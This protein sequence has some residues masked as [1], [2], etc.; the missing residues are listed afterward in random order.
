M[1][2]CGPDS[3]GKPGRCFWGCLWGLWREVPDTRPVPVSPRAARRGRR[4]SARILQRQ[5]DRSNGGEALEIAG[6]GRGKVELKAKGPSANHTHES[7]GKGEV[8]QGTD[9]KPGGLSVEN[10]N[11]HRPAR[12]LD[13]RGIPRNGSETSGMGWPSWTS[14]RSPWTD[15]GKPPPPYLPEASLAVRRRREFGQLEGACQ[16]PGLKVELHGC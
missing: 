3:Y 14:F 13:Y 4:D 16:L 6:V 11:T 10:I 2:C 15:R 8:A 9:G 1:Q 5:R 7:R 12:G